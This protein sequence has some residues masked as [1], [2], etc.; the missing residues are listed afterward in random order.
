MSIINR[1]DSFVNLFSGIG[2]SRD[3]SRLGRFHRDRALEPE[4]CES[5]FQGSDLA[6]RGCSAL[7]DHALRQGFELEHGDEGDEND[8]QEQ[9]DDLAT[10]ARRWDVRGKV[11]E[12]AVWGRVFGGSA[13]WIGIDEKQADPLDETKIRPGSVRFLAVVDRR[14]LSPLRLYDDPTS[15]KFG[16]PKTYT[17]SGLDGR[18]GAEIHESRLLIF[19]GILT[20]RRSRLE[21]N[22]W[23]HSA[24]QPVYEVLQDTES[25]WRSLV[26]LVADFGQGVFKIKGLMQMVAAG[27]EDTVRKRMQIVDEGRS[28][29][30]SLILDSEDEDY[31]RKTTPVQ[32]LP[33]IMIQTWQR[34]AAGWDM[35]VTI[36]MGMSPAGLNA[37]GEA[38]T[39]KWYDS[40]Q[41]F[42]EVVLAP[43]IEFLMRVLAANDGTPLDVRVCWPSLWQM[44]AKEE[45]ELRKTVAETDKLY[46]DAQVVLPEEVA[47]E[48]N[49]GGPP[50]STFPNIDMDARQA[51]L[52]AETKRAIE[53]AG[54]PPPAPPARPPGPTVPPPADGTPTQTDA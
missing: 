2:T 10:L 25:N 44:T 34:L 38:D 28:V 33:E 6:R 20:S 23:D 3:K 50:R 36:L 53:T 35:P 15:E 14:E 17:L 40:V 31:E 54:N 46:I 41:W 52:D 43:R 5:M 21:N 22:H 51:M 4:T 27:Q 7:V 32:G 26:A 1:L 13:I 29:L 11:H 19:P 9:N 42:R 39:R 18:P 48:R 37:T 16:T 47:I 12:A 24:L 30:R 45:A 8:A 49:K